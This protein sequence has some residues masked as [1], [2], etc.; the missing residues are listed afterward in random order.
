MAID[1]L[2]IRVITDADELEKFQM[3]WD[4]LAADSS[5]ASLYG[6]PD[7]LALWWKCFAVQE[8]R[9]FLMSRGLN[10][11]G[12]SISIH[13][14]VAESASGPVAFLPLM[15]IHVKPFN[16]TKVI[17]CL[18]FIGDE[19]F[20]PYA[21]LICRKGEDAAAVEAIADYLTE[22]EDWDALIFAPIRSDDVLIN[23][24][25][26]KLKKRFSRAVYS[27][28]NEVLYSKNWDRPLVGKILTRLEAAVSLDIEKERIGSYVKDL[29]SLTE[30]AFSRDCINVWDPRLR[31]ITAELKYSKGPAVGIINELNTALMKERPY[32]MSQIKLPS[33]VAMY[34]DKL[35]KKK[36]HYL[37]AD[38][39]TAADL[40]IEFSFKQSLPPKS[41]QSFIALHQ[42]RHKR[43]VHFNYLTLDYYERLLRKAEMLR[44]IE[45]LTVEA[46]SGEMILANLYLSDTYRSSF[47]YVVSGAK[48]EKVNLG[49]LAV[50]RGIEH[51]IS[52]NFNFFSFRFGGESYKSRFQTDE[53]NLCCSIIPRE[54]SVSGLLPARWSLDHE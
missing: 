29:E 18:C 3:Q 43:S 21:S 25:T 54:Q 12:E 27:Q 19:I 35:S 30:T 28:I 24:L 4:F 26:K 47:D 45:W 14:I 49:D 13:A 9:P 1:S 5:N 6:R 7:L 16:E 20:S 50:M 10:L 31:K 33:E 40:N 8:R 46:A 52:R 39:K 32:I 42:Q 36:K 38:S 48:R 2:K 53:I 11:Y 15:Q 37:R 22:A 17:T 44:K 23:F 41:F 34:E 51:A